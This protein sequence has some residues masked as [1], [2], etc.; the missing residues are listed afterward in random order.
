MVKELNQQKEYILLSQGYSS[1]QTKEA[2]TEGKIKTVRKY[3]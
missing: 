3:K 2:S 1:G